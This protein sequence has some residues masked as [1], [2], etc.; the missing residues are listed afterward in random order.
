M[1]DLIHLG[2]ESVCRD[3]CCL[4]A[5]GCEVL[6]SP[7]DVAASLLRVCLDRGS[8][9]VKMT[10]IAS[11]GLSDSPVRAAIV[12]PRCMERSW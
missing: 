7:F 8:K 12:L 4:L 6:V 2:V 10:G 1:D 5:V 3:G 11:V 9:V